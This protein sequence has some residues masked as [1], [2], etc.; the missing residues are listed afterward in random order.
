MYNN[1]GFF[2]ENY[3]QIQLSRKAFLAL[4]LYIYKLK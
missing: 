4:S 2:G 3:I 1:D